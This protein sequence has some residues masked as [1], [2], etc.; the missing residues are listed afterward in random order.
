M[1]RLHIDVTD[2]AAE[3]DLALEHLRRGA[4]VL[5]ERD[6]AVVAR[7]APPDASSGEAPSNQEL[8]FSFDDFT[9]GFDSF[10]PNSNTMAAAMA[11]L[12]GNGAAQPSMMDSWDE[13]AQEEAF[14][15]MLASEGGTDEI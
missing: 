5:L 6:G 1:A 3:L 4:D 7:L 12:H 2:L 10:D 8:R 13:L 9:N 11:L 14:L 15:E